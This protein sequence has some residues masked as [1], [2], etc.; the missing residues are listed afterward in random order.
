MSFL[1]Y[2]RGRPKPLTQIVGL[3]GLRSA[4][5]HL[6][7]L[8]V[9]L[10]PDGENWIFIDGEAI[11]TAPKGSIEKVVYLCREAMLRIP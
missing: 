1:S 8:H 11:Y 5:G 9:S 2:F 6:N 3:P 4:D 7:V 10:L